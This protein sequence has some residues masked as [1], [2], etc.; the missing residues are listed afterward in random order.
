MFTEMPELM[1]V[2]R[3][4]LELLSGGPV[5]VDWVNRNIGG[6]ADNYNDRFPGYDGIY[7]E[8]KVKVG[9]FF[10][11]DVDKTA[12]WFETD[13]VLLGNIK[14]IEMIV[15]GRAEKLLLFVDTQ[16]EGNAP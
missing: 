5:T 2:V 15:I 11:F 16:L 13:N 1:K 4:S 7:E 6:I 14:P 3:E 8:I 9:S 12:L 10:E